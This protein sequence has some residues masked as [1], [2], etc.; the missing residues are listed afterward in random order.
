MPF[1]AV[2]SVKVGVTVSPRGTALSSV[3]VN[4]IRSPSV[5]EASVTLTAGGPS[6][7]RI[8]PVAVATCV[9]DALSLMVKVSSSSSSSSSIVATVKVFVSPAV[10]A[11]VGPVAVTR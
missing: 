11:K 5:A 2:P 10:P 8:V 4:I 3:S 1:V 7:S 9:P 6:S